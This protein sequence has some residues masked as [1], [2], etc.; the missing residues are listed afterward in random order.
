MRTRS[1][2]GLNG[3]FHLSDATPAWRVLAWLDCMQLYIY[4]LRIALS[5]FRTLNRYMLVPVNTATCTHTH[6]APCVCVYMLSV[7][8]VELEHGMNV[9]CNWLQKTYTLLSSFH[10]MYDALLAP[11]VCWEHLLQPI[12]VLL[13]TGLHHLNIVCNCFIMWICCALTCCIMWMHFVLASHSCIA[14]LLHHV[15]IVFSGCSIVI[16][17]ALAASFKCIVC[18]LQHLHECTVH[19]LRHVIV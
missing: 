4:K 6:T 1:W 5:Y 12:I 2:L 16:N 8:Y 7:L 3:Y 18:W 10:G 13:W 11:H 17:C 14:C 15:N 19:V 9:W